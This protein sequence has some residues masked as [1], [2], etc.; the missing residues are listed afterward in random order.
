MS[1]ISL[2][3]YLN[4]RQKELREEREAWEAKK[5]E[6]ESEITT[7]QQRIAI[8]SSGLDLTFIETAEQAFVFRGD[9]RKY[10]SAGK[11]IADAAKA[12]AENEDPLKKEY[13]GLKN[14][15]RWVGQRC[16]CGYGMGPRHGSIVFAI[17]RRNPREPVTEAERE[18]ALYYLNNWVAV[19]EARQ[20]T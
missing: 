19:L 10:G 8:C 15:D 18:A 4:S 20:A 16:D 17:G 14:Y 11:A 6:L 1:L 9:P 7:T 5:A 2:T 12:I 3:N 13:I